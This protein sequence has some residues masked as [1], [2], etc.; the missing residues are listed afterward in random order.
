M[1]IESIFIVL[2]IGA[3]AGWLAGLLFRGYGFGLL[4]NILIGIVGGFIGTWILG[5][6]GVTM[7][8]GEWVSPI[9]TALLGASA[10]LLVIGL[11]RG[12]DGRRF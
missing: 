9:L 4:G 6:F 11:I 5:E 8:G 3:I 10:L 12:K 7:P 1:S 2:L